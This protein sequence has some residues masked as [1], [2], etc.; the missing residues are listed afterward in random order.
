MLIK[1][2]TNKA[3]E[4]LLANLEGKKD[5]SIAK[6]MLRCGFA[7]SPVTPPDAD[8]L[9]EILK[10]ILKD[11]NGVLYYCKDKDI[12]I[13]WVGSAKEVMSKIQAEVIKYCLQ[14]K[15]DW[16]SA[17]FFRYFDVAAHGEDLRIILKKK[18]ARL[19]PG[20]VKTVKLTELN[21]TPQQYSL[22]IN[23]IKNRAGRFKPEV[24]IVEDQV[25]SRTLLLGILAKEYKCH[26]ANNAV[27]ALAQYAS[28]APD[29]ILL[30]IELPDAD[31]HAIAKFIRSIDKDV[32]IIMVTANHYQSDVEKAKENG[33]QGFI[34]KPYNKQKILETI[35]KYKK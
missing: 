16:K 28:A 34:V 27:A 35:G 15:P 26:V 20:Q 25:F 29:I 4:A 17:D 5:I 14:Q 13:E 6:S 19:H 23:S 22:F 12:F 32:W 31:G 3:E 1:T 9:I 11:Y 7:N 30:D 21:F 24:L 8:K 33:V 2:V 18:I 10:D